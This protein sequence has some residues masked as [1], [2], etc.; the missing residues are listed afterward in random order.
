MTAAADANLP[1]LHV[2]NPLGRF[3][4]RAA[5]YAKYRPTYP[6]EAI[7]QILQGLEPPSLQ[8]ADIGAGTGISARLLADRGIGVW[9]IEP[10]DAMRSSAAPHPQVNWITGTAEQTNLAEDFV[11]IVLCAQSFHWFD[12]QAALIEF[13][14]ILKPNGRVALMWN[15]RN[16][17]D[18]FTQEYSEVIGKV[19]DRQIFERGDRKSPDRLAESP[20]FTN[21]QHH[22]FV[23]AYSLDQDSLI[24]LVLSASYIPKA[25][26]AAEQLIINLQEL[27]NR[28]VDRS[29][30]FVSLSYRTSLYIAEP[31]KQ[32]L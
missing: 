26:A 12:K 8:A 10:N 24:G 2:Q 7:E 9:A 16:L 22:E 19:A 13:H 15:D 20:L 1:P 25:G 28:W 31:V 4:D 32:R 30:G 29:T 21:F 23:H 6:P 17:D 18:S 3:S 5:D 14:R 11:E 27:Y